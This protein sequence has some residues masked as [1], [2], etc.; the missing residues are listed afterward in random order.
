[1]PTKE[2]F[3][4]QFLADFSDFIDAQVPLMAKAYAMAEE[5]GEKEAAIRYESRLNAYEFLQ[6]KFDNYKNGK[7]FHEMSGLTRKTF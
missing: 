4:S 2:S 6:G 1:M 7:P 5:A 3:D